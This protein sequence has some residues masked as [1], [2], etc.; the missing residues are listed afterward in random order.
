MWRRHFA[1]MDAEIR[2]KN[3]FAA[4]AAALRSL[5]Q[6]GVL[7]HVIWPGLAAV[8][9][10]FGLAALFWGQVAVWLGQWLGESYPLGQFSHY[11]FFDLLWAIIGHFLL[12]AL[13]LPLVYLT[14]LL[15][16][17]VFALPMMLSRVADR[18]Y[19]ELARRY[20][21]SL[22]GSLVNTLIAVLILA[23]LFALS[24]PLWL[25]P[26][27]V[28]VLPTLLSGWLNQR[29]YGY[30]ALMMHADADEL[31]R[32]RRDCR[33]GLFMIGV[34]AGLLV[35]IPIANLLAPA[36]AGLASVHYC[37]SAL[38]RARNGGRHAE[39]CPL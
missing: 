30:D 6:L 28:L 38:R 1:R 33:G 16:F 39:V 36:F 3:L 29:I 21:G 13:L 22:T 34:M 31:A 4:L 26:G 15:I 23:V 2:M 17:G 25:V 35:W 9:L 8:A 5:T 19:A 10:W 11:A 32:L 20:G 37:L 7:W 12:A 18:D 14:A 27:M 24:L